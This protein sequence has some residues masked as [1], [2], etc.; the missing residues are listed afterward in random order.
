MNVG[1][2]ILSF[3]AAILH[4]GEKWMLNWLPSQY[5]F[6][7]P[8]NDRKIVAYFQKGKQWPSIVYLRFYS[9]TS[10]FLFRRRHHSMI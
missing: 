3:C 10:C 1:V 6:K 2:I 8:M 7:S 5:A 4:T 9:I